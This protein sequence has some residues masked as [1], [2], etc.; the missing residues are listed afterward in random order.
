MRFVVPK[1]LLFFDSNIKK[2]RSNLQC[3]SRI[4]L[5]IYFNIIKNVTH[6]VPPCGSRY[7]SYP[8]KSADNFRI[9]IQ[10]YQKLCVLLSR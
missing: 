8:N 9:M 3:D 4:K 5:F 2:A 1:L 6:A 10:S 7:S